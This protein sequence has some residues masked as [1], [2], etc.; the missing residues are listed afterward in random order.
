[1]TRALAAVALA[2]S[3]MAGTTRAQ[4]ESH[5]MTVAELAEFCRSPDLAAHNACKF[6]ILGAVQ[7][8]GLDARTYCIPDASADGLVIL[9]RDAIAR[10]LEFHPDDAK[11]DAIGMVGAVV[12]LRF[13]CRR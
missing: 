13:A 4:P 12:R 6:Y 11:L 5:S 10:D 3:L 7:A 1:M 8:L 9:V 2:A